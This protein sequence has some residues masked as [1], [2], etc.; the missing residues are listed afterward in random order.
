MEVRTICRSCWS[1]CGILVDVDENQ[2]VL[3]VRGDHDHPM[4][5]GYMCP[6]G[7]ALPWAHHRPDRLNYPVLR[8]Q[9]TNWDALLDDLTRT[10]EKAIAAHG[11]DAIGSYV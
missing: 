3:G 5:K 2:Q 4:S 6:K 10:I 11:P 9:Q 7:A 1:G 8:G